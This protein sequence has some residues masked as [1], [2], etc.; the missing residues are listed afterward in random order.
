MLKLR[1]TIDDVEQTIKME[2]SLRSVSKWE[3]EKERLFFP[4]DK[5]TEISGI[6]MLD[7]F[8][9]MILDRDDEKHVINSMT[10]NDYDEI[11]RYIA[12][13]RTATTVKEIQSKPGPK[14]NISSELIYY[15]MI[16]FNIPFTA[17]EWHLNRLMTLIRVCSAK[18][19]K[20][21]KRDP[22]AMAQDFRKLNEQRK[23]QLGTSG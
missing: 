15:W 14:E 12:S 18:N 23:Q 11:T 6:D 22:K 9:Y 19:T 10:N 4:P 21:Q 5:K 16:S 13:S 17:D 20:Q 1:V 7:Y 2:H 3:S 8:C